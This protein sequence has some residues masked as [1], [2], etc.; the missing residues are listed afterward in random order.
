LGQGK[1]EADGIVAGAFTIK[2]V[3]PEK[4]TIG[5]AEIVSVKIDADLDGVDDQTLSAGKEV[6]VLTKS[7]SATAKI[8]L[9]PQ[10]NPGGNLWV[11]KIY[12]N[13]TATYTG[14]RIKCSQAVAEDV[15]V[16][17]WIVEEE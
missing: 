6:E 4:K 11:E 2:V 3:D 9:T 17:W 15:K 12:D 13:M 8:F 14:F 16:D 7:V 1:L 10:G 5:Q